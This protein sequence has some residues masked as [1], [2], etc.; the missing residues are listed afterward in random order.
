M[1]HRRSR[2]AGGPLYQIIAHHN[3]APGNAGAM[4]WLDIIMPAIGLAL[5]IAWRRAIAAPLPRS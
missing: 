4:F 1:P 2:A 5:L 3:F